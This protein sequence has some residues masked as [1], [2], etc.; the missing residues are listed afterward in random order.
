MHH[1]VA[2]DLVRV[3]H[4]GAKA[5]QSQACAF[6]G[7]HGQDDDGTPIAVATNRATEV[8]KSRRSIYTDYLFNGGTRRHSV[9]ATTETRHMAVGH[10]HQAL[11]RVVPPGLHSRLPGRRDGE[12]GT[13]EFVEW[14]ESRTRLDL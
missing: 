1:Q 10:N 2:A 3:R 13:A 6:D 14:E 7:S 4:G 5:E 9:G 8:Y 11:S 12:W